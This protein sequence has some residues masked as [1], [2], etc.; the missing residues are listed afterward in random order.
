MR[1]TSRAPSYDRDI[2]DQ[3]R[4]GYTGYVDRIEA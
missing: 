2:S 4:Q 3:E 1:W